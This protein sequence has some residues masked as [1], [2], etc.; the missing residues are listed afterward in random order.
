MIF[1]WFSSR[2]FWVLVMAIMLVRTHLR[3]LSSS[4]LEAKP[5]HVKNAH[6]TRIKKVLSCLYSQG[7]GGSYF[8][9]FTVNSANLSCHYYKLRLIIYSYRIANM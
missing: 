8:E 6:S 7:E 5:N 3:G 2:L 4:A 9:P 1:C